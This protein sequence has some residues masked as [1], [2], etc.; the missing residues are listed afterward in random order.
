MQRCFV[1]I[2]TVLTCVGC[3]AHR[4]PATAPTTRPSLPTTMQISLTGHPVQP[5]DP[6]DPQLE[7]T[8][9]IHLDVYQLDLP[10]GAVSRN[11]ALWKRVDEQAV[12]A[13][14]GTADLLFKNGLRCGVAPRSE[15][16]FFRDLLGGQPGRMRQTKVNGTHG[17]AVTLEMDTPVDHEDIFYFDASNQM[18]GRTFESC[19]NGVSLSFQP[20]PRKQSSV[21]IALAPTIRGERRR[22][23]FT[24]ANQEYESPFAEVTRLYDLSLRV[25]VADDSFLV[26]APSEDASRSTS[27]GAR[28][29]TTE[30]KA[31]RLERVLLIVPSFLRL[32]GKPVTYTETMARQ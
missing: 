25:D 6:R 24:P 20:A 13:G 19:V 11:D 9:L 22:L 30:D 15:W 32:D 23:E 2:M 14:E 10:M 7:L 28:F 8:L 5:A 27:I 3:Q 17:D 26:V 31:E 12:G 1:S 16:S 18:V 4:A 29:F 21:R